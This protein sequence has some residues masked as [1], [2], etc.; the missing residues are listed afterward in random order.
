MDE[1]NGWEVENFRI[2]LFLV[3]LSNKINNKAHFNKAQMQNL[4]AVSLLRLH[5]KYR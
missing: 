1:V 5:Q 4:G 2:L 3:L